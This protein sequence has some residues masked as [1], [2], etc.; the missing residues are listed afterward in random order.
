MSTKYTAVVHFDGGCAPNPGQKYGSYS[1]CFDDLFLLEKKRVPF[2]HGTNNEAEFDACHAALQLLRASA[3]KAAVPETKI[4]VKLF[5]DSRIV[6][7][8]VNAFPSKSTYKDERRQAMYD[9]AKK[10]IDIL[11]AFASFEIEW[12]SRDVNMEKFGH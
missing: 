5:T 3:L 2:G 11:R 10:C 8:W 12:N 6:W 9:R 7:N 1:I 4:A